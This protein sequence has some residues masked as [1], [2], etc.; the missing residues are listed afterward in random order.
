MEV[1]FD[2]FVTNDIYSASWFTNLDNGAANNLS[3]TTNINLPFSLLKPIDLLLIMNLAQYS[4][5][6]TRRPGISANDSNTM[7]PSRLKV[8]WKVGRAVSSSVTHIV[9][10]C[11]KILS[12]C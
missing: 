5:M 9:L 3:P 7:Q 6:L 11:L 1:Q 2:S 4:T 8:L 12:V 10:L